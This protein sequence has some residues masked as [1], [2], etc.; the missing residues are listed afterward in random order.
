MKSRL[1][2]KKNNFLHVLLESLFKLS[3]YNAYISHMSME[4]IYLVKRLR[5]GQSFVENVQFFDVKPT[6][7][8]NQLFVCFLCSEI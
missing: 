3:K 4:N 5:F 8:N 2:V 1:G 6:T 7:Q